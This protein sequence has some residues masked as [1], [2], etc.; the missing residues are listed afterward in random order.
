MKKKPLLKLMSV[1]KEL[2]DYPNDGFGYVIDGIVDYLGE[3]KC[4]A[5]CRNY[6]KHDNCPESHDDDFDTF[7]WCDHFSDRRDDEQYRQ[8]NGLVTDFYDKTLEEQR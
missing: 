7:E 6:G 3:C 1:M 8:P 5:F 4:C 2:E